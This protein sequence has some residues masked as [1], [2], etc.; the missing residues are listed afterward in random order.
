MTFS[1]AAFDFT[2]QTV[3]DSITNVNFNSFLGGYIW[4]VTDSFKNTPALKF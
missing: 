4:S 2:E 1:E 3:Q